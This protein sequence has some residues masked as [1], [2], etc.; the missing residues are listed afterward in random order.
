MAPAYDLAFSSGP[1]GQQSTMVMGEGIDSGSEHLLKLGLDAKPAKARINQIIGT[2]GQAVVPI[3][4]AR[5]GRCQ[6]PYRRGARGEMFGGRKSLLTIVMLLQLKHLRHLV[7][8][9]GDGYDYSLSPGGMVHLDEMKKCCDRMCLDFIVFCMARL[10]PQNGGGMQRVFQRI[11]LSAS[12]TARIP[13]E[14]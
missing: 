14:E 9:T 8:F 10:N 7:R 6:L 13:S 2:P 1:G 3:G 11:D 4:S 12:Q 5:I